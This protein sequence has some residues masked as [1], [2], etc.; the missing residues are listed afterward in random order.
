M[1]VYVREDDLHHLRVHQ[2]VDRL[3]VDVGDQIPLPQAGIVGRTL[4]LHM[5]RERE[6]EERGGEKDRER[7][8]DRERERET[9]TDR[10]RETET[11]RQR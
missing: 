9:E 2:A 5:L 6:K 7:D 10:E 4:G 3:S 8:R 11:Q 1:C